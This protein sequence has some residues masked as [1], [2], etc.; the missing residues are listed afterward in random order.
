VT[1]RGANH[2]PRPNAR[3]MVC[4]ASS[5]PHAQVPAPRSRWPGGSTP[6]GTWSTSRRR[7]ARLDR[8]PSAA[9]V[10]ATIDKAASWAE[11]VK[12][13]ARDQSRRRW[14][15]PAVTAGLH[16][17]RPQPATWWRERWPFGDDRFVHEA[18]GFDVH[19]VSFAD[20]EQRP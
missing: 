15:L 19:I 3:V 5:S 7:R 8:R 9:I 16:H 17:D 2:D 4:V 12:L 6:T 13:H 1:A 14:I 10:L 20:E 11:V 18:D